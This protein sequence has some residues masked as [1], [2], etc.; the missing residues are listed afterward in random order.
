MQKNKEW[1]DAKKWLDTLG[2]NKANSL[3]SALKA[4]EASEE[5][6][7][8]LRELLNNFV[9]INRSSPEVKWIALDDLAKVVESVLK[10]KK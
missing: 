7:A 3:D 10:E 2:I 5:E 9:E 4:F 6:N 1:L 8:F